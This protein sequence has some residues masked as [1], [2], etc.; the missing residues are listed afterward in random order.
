MLLKRLVL[1]FTFRVMFFKSLFIL[2]L[3]LILKLE[4]VAQYTEQTVICI[5]LRNRF[6]MYFS[7]FLNVPRTLDAYSGFFFF[8][9]G[10]IMFDCILYERTPADGHRA[11]DYYRFGPSKTFR[12]YFWPENKKKKKKLPRQSNGRAIE[13]LFAKT[14]RRES[15][16]D[17]WDATAVLLPFY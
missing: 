12:L 10:R 17:R 7:E 8:L 4:K 5:P 14:Y 6:R 16:R 15:G 1:Y 11:S 9:N 2:I 3:I 13:R